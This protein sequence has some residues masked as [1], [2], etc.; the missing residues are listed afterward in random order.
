MFVRAHR[1]VRFSVT[2][3][4][5]CVAAF[6]SVVLWDYY[7][8]A[9][10][11][12]NGQVRVQVANIAP[13]VSGQI[14]SVPVHDNEHVHKGDLLYQIDPF[15]FRVALDK[16]KADVDKA[17]AD[18]EFR[19]NQTRWRR[20][21][22]GSAVSQEEKKQYEALAKQAE[23]I[24]GTTLAQLRQAQINLDRTSVRSS[25]DGVVTNLTMRPG[26]FASAGKVNIH[27]ID[28]ASFWVDGYFEEVKVHDL[29][30]GDRV[31]M[32]LMGYHT[33]LYGHVTSI[34]R[35]IASANAVTNSLGLPMVDPVYTWVRLA[36]RIPV[37]VAI[38]TIPPNLTLS[39]GMTVTVTAISEEGN[40]RRRSSSDAFR[41]LA[42]D[43]RHLF[44][45]K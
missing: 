28:T 16:A 8:A 37:R 3:S 36:Q 26:D 42:D 32:D 35:G 10:W 41:H 25:I 7:T 38:D 22:P 19:Q 27:I 24:Y 11:T 29:T 20:N 30:E 2:A 1:L 4:I 6:I 13:R 44:G 34:T 23:A 15:D 40:R 9:P 43:F 12:R 18:L 17:K 45:Y 5:L 14:L 21:I 31:R 39:A 33:P